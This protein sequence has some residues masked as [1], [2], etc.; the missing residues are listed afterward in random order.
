MR[1]PAIAIFSIGLILLAACGRE[2]QKPMTEDQAI[3]TLTSVPMQSTRDAFGKRKGASVEGLRA[4]LE[5][6]IKSGKIKVNVPGRGALSA[7]NFDL[8]SL[9]SI[10]A[11]LQ[12][13]GSIFGLAQGLLNQAGSSTGA[14]FNIDTIMAILN[15]ALPII[16]TIAPQYAMIVQALTFILPLVMNIIN[17]FKKPKPTPTAFFNPMMPVRA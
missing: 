17:L 3:N 15:A 16:M 4:L 14:K 6:L 11:L 7:T 2:Y 8:S 13:G 9:N 1:H 12:Q 5:E 10:F